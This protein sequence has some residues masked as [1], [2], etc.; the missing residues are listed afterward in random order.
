M[1]RRG[2]L[3]TFLFLALTTLGAQEHDHAALHPTNATPLHLAA[4]VAIPAEANR[5]VYRPARCDEQ[6]NIYFRAYQAEERKVPIVRADLKGKTTRYSLDSDPAFAAAT[7]Y[8]F[9]VLP[10]GKLFQP[11]QLGK[12]IYIVAFDEKGA[13]VSKTRLEKQFWVSRLIAFDD[14]KFLVIGTEP[15]SP[16][17]PKETRTYHPV[18]DIF[19]RNGHLVRSV[20]LTREA[21]ETE[22]AVRPAHKKAAASGDKE[23]QSGDKPDQ[24][25]EKKTAPPL[26]AVLS[27][28][29]QADSDGKVYLMVHSEPP[30]VYAVDAVSGSVRSWEITPPAERMAAVSLSLRLGHLAVQFRHS[31]QGMSH[32]EDIIRVVDLAHGG[33]QTSEFSV[34]TELANSALACFQQDEAVFIGP[35]IGSGAG[36]DAGSLA[37][38]FARPDKR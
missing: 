9:S 29:G 7:A 11:V 5:P 24:A 10:N 25:V 28:D 34:P 22:S 8:D 35:S 13:I 38:Q 6:G 37:I 4:K 36:S 12:D 27:S 18:V 31:F 23:T 1:L 21:G 3:A 17:A 33:A 14:S 15:Q 16:D 2:I 20:S 19:D 26:L 30:V 32:G